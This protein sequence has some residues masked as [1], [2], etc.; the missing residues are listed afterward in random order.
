[1]IRLLHSFNN[2][3]RRNRN[4]GT[5]KSGYK[6]QSEFNIPWQNHKPFYENLRTSKQYEKIV[7]GKKYYFIVEKLKR[8]YIYSCSIEDICNILKVVPKNDLEGLELIIFR[9]PKEKEEFISPS[10]G[11]LMYLYEHQ[12]ELKPAI[13]MEAVNLEKGTKFKNKG[14]SPFFKREIELLRQEGN[15]IIN[16]G[17]YIIINKSFE[18]ARNTQLFRTLLHEIGHFVYYKQGKNIKNHEENEDFANR[19]AAS[20]K[21]LL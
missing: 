9:Q 21:K 12:G 7:E 5:K 4:I 14:I 15:H 8:N 3:S 1:M 11:R 13:I 2:P 17:K 6:K 10:W 20:I 19:Y 16:D 18:S